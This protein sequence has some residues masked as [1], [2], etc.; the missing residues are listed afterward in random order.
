MKEQVAMFWQVSGRGGVEAMMARLALAFADLEVR[1]KVLVIPKT[2]TVPEEVRKRLE[3]Q[4]LSVRHTGLALPWLAR[5][6]G[7]EKPHALLAAK[8]RA[9]QV[10]VLAQKA[11]GSPCR[12]VLR[13]G[14]TPTAALKAK[15]LPKL[16]F[17]LPMRL[18]YPQARWVAAVSSGVAQ[19][20]ARL[21]IPEEKIRVVPNPVVSP[22]IHTLA[23]AP[24]SHPW[25][26]DPLPVILGV[27]RLTPQKGF[28]VL[29]RSF[30]K[31]QADTPARLLI[32]GEGKERGRLLALAKA[33]G[34]AEKTQF[35]GHV[36]NPY[37]YFRRASLFVLSSFWE[38]SPN[39]LTEALALGV[40][41][42]AA[43][44]PSGPREILRGGEVAP[45]VPV[46]DVDA[47]AQAMRFSLHM[48]PAREKLMEAAIAFDAHESA[49][50]YL[51]LLLG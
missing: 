30:A 40:P 19:D 39:A 17:T 13:V 31:M 44:C 33:L 35:L 47:L 14:T 36:D 2:G 42:V 38:G 1:A 51:D 32:L 34:I 6:L 8:D 23:D 4:E 7:R 41:V 3:V 25:L 50:R 16:W 11:A 21:G 28:D 9:N 22:R 45:L 37:P 12:L 5:Y 15:R 20:L 46:G 10:A 48:P 27:G 18:L 26:E 24:L 49:K 43:D 29:L